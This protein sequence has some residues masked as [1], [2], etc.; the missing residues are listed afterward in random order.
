M[1]QTEKEAPRQLYRAL[2]PL[3]LFDRYWL[4]S[5]EIQRVISHSKQRAMEGQKMKYFP[6]GLSYT[7]ICFPWSDSCGDLAAVAGAKAG[8]NSYTMGKAK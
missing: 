7:F 6:S 3:P 4:W 1:G 8:F 2:I 5:F